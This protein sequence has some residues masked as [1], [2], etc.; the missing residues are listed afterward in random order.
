MKIYLFIKLTVFSI[1][2]TVIDREY[3]FLSKTYMYFIDITYTI[4]NE[5]PFEY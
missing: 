4:C 3:I 5:V 1:S 2:I